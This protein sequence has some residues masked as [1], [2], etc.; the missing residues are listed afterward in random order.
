MWQMMQPWYCSE[1][2]DKFGMEEREPVDLKLRSFLDFSL[3]AE[4]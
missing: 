3:A 1:E 2:G 4:Y